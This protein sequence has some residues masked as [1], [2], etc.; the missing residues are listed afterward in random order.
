MPSRS[1]N[2]KKYKDRRGRRSTGKD[3]K[4]QESSEAGGE[5]HTIGRLD[6]LQKPDR[7]LITERE[8]ST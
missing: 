7:S 4:E 3:K 8:L 6:D 5:G 1:C 2:R